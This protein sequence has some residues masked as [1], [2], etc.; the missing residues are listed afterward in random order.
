MAVSWPRQAS[1]RSRPQASRR[2]RRWV[3]HSSRLAAE[4]AV[5]ALQQQGQ[6][7]IEGVSP[8]APEPQF[9]NFRQFA[10][11]LRLLGPGKAEVQLATV[12]QQLGWGQ[13]HPGP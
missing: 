11:I 2:N 4:L 1:P 7:G 13:L 12:S 10:G 5:A 3:I 6:P 8:Q 9:G